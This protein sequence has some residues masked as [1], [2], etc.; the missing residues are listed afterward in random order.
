MTI[1]EQANIEIRQAKEQLAF[2][3]LRKIAKAVDLSYTT[4]CN[5]T[6][7]KL[8]NA[9]TVIKVLVEMKKII[10]QRKKALAS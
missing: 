5:A 9:D 3:D 1:L 2:R 10:N 6:L 4:V 8:T 7:G